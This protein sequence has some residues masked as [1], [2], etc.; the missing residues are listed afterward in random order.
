MYS[1]NSFLDWPFPERCVQANG[2]EARKWMI[3]PPAVFATSSSSD[4]L[5][6]SLR[7]TCFKEHFQFYALYIDE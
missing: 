3:F 5:V 2:R 4:G 7:N 6:L 1:P